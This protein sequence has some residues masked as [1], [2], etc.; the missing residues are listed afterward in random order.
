MHN[1]SQY[2]TY[3]N[4]SYVKYC[5]SRHTACLIG[6]KST[7][8]NSLEFISLHYK[9]F[10]PIHFQYHLRLLF[11]RLITA[12]H[13]RMFCTKYFALEVC[14]FID[15]CDTLQYR[16]KMHWLPCK[17]KTI[18]SALYGALRNIS[19]EI[20]DLKLN[21]CFLWLESGFSHFQFKSSKKFLVVKTSCV[22]PI[23]LHNFFSNTFTE[24][25]R[26]KKGRLRRKQH[27]YVN[28]P[29]FK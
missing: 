18:F 26:R 10:Y 2:I 12:Y 8:K 11:T 16:S 1:I 6:T 24:I 25:R 20:I 9:T 14:Y 27:N 4:I 15:S 17:K 29:V 23:W 21:V 13:S 7:W 28:A 3:R 5:T 22:S 19:G